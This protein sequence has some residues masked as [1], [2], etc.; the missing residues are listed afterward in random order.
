MGRM[1][2][3]PFTLKDAA[4]RLGITCNAAR[5]LVAAGKLQAKQFGPLRDIRFKEED[6]DE[7]MAKNDP[8]KVHRQI[9]QRIKAT[10]PHYQGF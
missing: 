1:E 5:R 10:E 3:Y 2:N 4:Q 9:I 6:I 8:A 7:L